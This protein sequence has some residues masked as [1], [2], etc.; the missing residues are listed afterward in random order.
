MT[1]REDKELLMRK[2]Q[3][4]P[5]ENLDM[6]RYIENTRLMQEFNERWKKPKKN[7]QTLKEAL[8]D[9]YVERNLKSPK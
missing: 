5:N 4:K 3:I 6:V 7:N 9:V 8:F 2:L 1:K